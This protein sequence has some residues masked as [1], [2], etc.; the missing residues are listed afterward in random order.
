MSYGAIE[1]SEVKKDSDTEIDTADPLVLE[2]T[3]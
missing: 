1:Y 3:F 2:P